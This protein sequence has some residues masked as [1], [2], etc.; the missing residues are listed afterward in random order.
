[1]MFTRGQY[2]GQYKSVNMVVQ[3]CTSMKENIFQ[4][5]YRDIMIC[6]TTVFLM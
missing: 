6:F 5:I 4:S 3:M 1:M 2:V